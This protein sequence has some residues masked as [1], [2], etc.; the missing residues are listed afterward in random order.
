MVRRQGRVGTGVYPAD[1]SNGALG[2]K[3]EMH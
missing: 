2:R 1:R 3:E